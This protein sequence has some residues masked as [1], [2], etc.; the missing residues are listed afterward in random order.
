MATSIERL[1]HRFADLSGHG[2]RPTWMVRLD[3]DIERAFG[4]V[5]FAV[6]RHAD[7]FDQI[8]QHQDPMGIHVHAHRWD[9]VTSTVFSDY[10]DE[11][12]TTYCLQVAAGTFE[13]CFGTRVRVAS[14]GGYFMS[15]SLLDA[16]V[17]LGIEADVTVEP[18]LAAKAVDPSMGAYASGPS[19]NFLNCPRQPY[20]PSRTAFDS[21]APIPGS[22]RPI[23]MVPLTSYDYRTALTPWYRKLSRQERW[24]PRRHEPL[25]PWKAWPGPREF[26]NLA[27]RAA[28]EGPARYLALALRTEAPGKD[29]YREVAR[30]FEFLPHHSIA[31][32][33]RFVDPLGPEIA[34]LAHLPGPS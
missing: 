4:R 22:A 27:E 2:M 15:E 13:R 31:R 26:W 34:R 7:L 9:P 5:D 25:N 32:R 6:H 21:P 14:Q 11:A 16:A 20:Y 3:P 33:L 1:R 18:G 28:D 8:R 12:W 19:G 24:R 30:L 10:A 23:L 29:M 17:A